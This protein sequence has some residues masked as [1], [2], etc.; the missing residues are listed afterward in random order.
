[1]GSRE[2]ALKSWPDDWATAWGAALGRTLMGKWAEQR[3]GSTPKIS[4]HKITKQT[5][6]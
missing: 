1:M 4:K 3:D 2:V 6:C 5:F